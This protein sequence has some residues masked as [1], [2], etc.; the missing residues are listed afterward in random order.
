MKDKRLALLTG[1]S[2]AVGKV[3]ARQFAENGWSLLLC[4]RSDNIVREADALAVEFNR[5]CLG[6]KMD[7]TIDADIKRVVAAVSDTDIPIQFWA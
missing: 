3:A 4:D 1:A 7:L 2:G 6:I 5:T